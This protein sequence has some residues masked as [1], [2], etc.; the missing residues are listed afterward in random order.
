MKKHLRKKSNELMNVLSGREVNQ[1]ILN[2][3]KTLWQIIGERPD[4]IP[5]PRS[6]G[7]KLD[8]WRM[9]SH[10]NHADFLVYT[11]KIDNKDRCVTIQVKEHDGSLRPSSE[12]YHEHGMK[13]K[14]IMNEISSLLAAV[15]SDGVTTDKF[16]TLETACKIMSRFSDELIEKSKKTQVFSFKGIHVSREDWEDELDM[17]EISDQE[18]DEIAEEAF[19]IMTGEKY[20]Y[21]ESQIREWGKNQY[22]YFNEEL[23]VDADNVIMGLLLS[24]G[25][26]ERDADIEATWHLFDDQSPERRWE[27]LV[28]CTETDR[29]KIKDLCHGRFNGCMVCQGLFD[30]APDGNW[31]EPF[32]NMKTLTFRE[33]K[34]L[35]PWNI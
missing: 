32:K 4:F 1:T 33:F 2:N 21:S 6:G 25:A 30:E 12:T 9:R 13:A 3:N 20:R 17:S 18:M 24:H 22:D 16:S 19:G 34:R 23:D 15:K 7:S 35:K 26:T 5:D 11:R 29:E 28:L 8:C 10:Q 31:K 14:L 27:Y